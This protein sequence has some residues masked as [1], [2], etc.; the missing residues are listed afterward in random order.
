METQGSPVRCVP[1]AAA[2]AAA[3]QCPALGTPRMGGS[4]GARRSRP[5]GR[6]R[7]AAPIRRAGST[8]GDP[9]ALWRAIL[10]TLNLGRA[11]G[12]QEEE[13]RPR[14]LTDDPKELWED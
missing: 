4:R 12:V 13:I 3:A 7:E 1:V 5:A 9:D 11:A 6:I 2:A 14:E 8:A 10:A